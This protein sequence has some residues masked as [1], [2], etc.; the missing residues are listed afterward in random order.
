MAEGFAFAA[1]ATEATAMMTAL[2][3]TI[4]H[5]GEEGKNGAD[6]R[7]IGRDFLYV[8]SSPSYS[9]CI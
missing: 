5:I 4:E 8:F 9:G 3:R 1:L 6:E 2:R 7:R